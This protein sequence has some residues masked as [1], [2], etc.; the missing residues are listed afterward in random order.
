MRDALAF[1]PFRL[2]PEQRVLLESGRPVRIGQRAFDILAVLLE[3]QGA[4]VGTEELLAIVWGGN[5][6]EPSAVRVQISALR[7]ALGD[8]RGD[9]RYITNI[10]GRGYCFVAPVT[11]GEAPAAAADIVHISTLPAQIASMYGRDEVIDALAGKLEHRLVT[12]VGA[13]G[14]GKTTVAVAAARS[15][16]AHYPDGVIFVDFAPLTAPAMV[17]N[18]L[19]AAAEIAARSDDMMADILAQL[20]DRQMLLVLDNCEH[21]IEAVSTLAEDLLR[22]T[23]GVRLLATS[24]EPLRC[25]GEWVLRLQPLAVP[26]A[27]DIPP[28]AEALSFPAVRL[29]VDR[30][31]ASVNAFAFTDADVAPVIEICRRLDGI[32]LAIELAAASVEQLGLA[33][34]AGELGDRFR[35]LTRGRRTALPRQRTLRAT[36]DWSYDMLSAAEQAILRRLAVLRGA[37][38]LESARAVAAD[39]HLAEEQV[40]LGISNLVA[41]SL[42]TTQTGQEP[43]T[44][45]MLETMRAYCLDRLQEADEL[46]A[47]TRRLA[48]CVSALLSRGDVA[49]PQR[50]LLIDDVS[51]AL[52]WAFSPHG[53]RHLGVALTLAAI[54]LW[55]EM[56]RLLECRRRVEQAIEGLDRQSGAGG[57]SELQLLVALATAMQNGAGPGKENTRLWQRANALAETLDDQ[58]SRLRTLWGLWIDCRNRGEHREG[59]LV[60]RRFQALAGLRNERD[61]ELVA[62]RMVGMSLFIL[63]DLHGAREHT[64]RMLAQYGAAS[65][66]GH[67][68]RF[69]FEQRAGAEFLL[70]MILW[71]QGFPRRAR[72]MLDDAV[73][74]VA[75]RGHAL[76]FSVLLA[77]FA[78]PIACLLGDIERLAQFVTRLL[79]SAERHGL[80]AWA[81]RGRCWQ[82]LLRIRQGQV[83]MGAEALERALRHF[84]GDGRAFQHVWLLAELAQ[85]QAETGEGRTARQAVETALER[86]ELGGELWCVPELLRIRGQVLLSLALPAEAEA[87]LQQSLSLSR[88]QAALAWE[89]RTAT[90]LGRHLCAQGRHGEAMALLAP[91]CERFDDGLETADLRAA[92]VVL[93]MAA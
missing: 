36:L 53:D 46:Q 9:R 13:G 34:L 81:A 5:T 3:R 12:I 57:H 11:R 37:F 88:E 56:T 48:E 93:G 23:T 77:Q 91:V 75:A 7:R 29:F 71:L 90:S 69:H 44:Y 89:L 62:D 86:A 22:G 20:A 87:M 8:G 80:T 83:T 41:K 27:N 63:G 24:R 35:V 21:V 28:A 4:V 52:D 45:R 32:P 51:A 2:L 38:S 25:Q 17:P 59:L 76:Q 55:I 64:E 82:A 16:A 72:E 49:K 26:P 74:A 68:V 85:A 65:D 66:A 42:L 6:A 47:T 70:A 40:I 73:A 92:R 78:C 50:R 30:A 79:D 10:A 43:V 58:D 67:M 84:P 54:P 18:A 1:G 14:I 15:F 61:D 19:A 31:M 60:A 33:G 39:A